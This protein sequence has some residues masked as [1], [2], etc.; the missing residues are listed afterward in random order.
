[1]LDN[2]MNRRNYVD[3]KLLP[4]PILLVLVN[5]KRFLFVCQIDN[6]AEADWVEHLDNVHKY[7]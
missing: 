1:M 3:Q 7:P 2:L 5:T 6:G 4:D